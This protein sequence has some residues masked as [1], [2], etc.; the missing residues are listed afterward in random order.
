MQE[1]LGTY[2]LFERYEQLLVIIIHFSNSDSKW[3][4]CYL[5]LHASL[6]I[7]WKKAF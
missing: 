5:K 6:D 1:L 2:L 4:K 7:L 3:L